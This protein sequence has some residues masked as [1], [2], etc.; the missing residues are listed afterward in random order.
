MQGR[1]L[2]HLL[3]LD[4]LFCKTQ[5]AITSNRLLWGLKNVKISKVHVWPMLTTPSM[6][7]YFLPLSTPPFSASLSSLKTV[8]CLLNYMA[9]AAMFKKPEIL[10]VCHEILTL[11]YI[12]PNMDSL[13]GTWEHF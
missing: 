13:A 3:N 9:S 5:R 4:F 1:D 8:I 7:P 12:P 6:F 2:V 11:N 10:T